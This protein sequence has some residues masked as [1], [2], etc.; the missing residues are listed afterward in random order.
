[1]LM[2]RGSK[3]LGCREINFSHECSIPLNLYDID[4]GISLYH[5][6]LRIILHAMSSLPSWLACNCW[7]L[8]D[9]VSLSI[10]LL[11]RRREQSGLFIIRKHCQGYASGWLKYIVAHGFCIDLSWMCCRRVCLHSISSIM[12]SVEIPATHKI[13][14]RIELD[15]WN[16]RAF[17]EVA[18]IEIY[19]MRMW[20]KCLLPGS[21]SSASALCW[22]RA[23]ATWYG[24]CINFC[25]NSVWM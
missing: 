23:W 13:N 22:W 15:V 12:S 17:L 6:G 24:F 21:C 20:F 19:N 1:M 9:V 4:S 11:R 2:I 10:L 3:R 25:E 7:V 8:Q 18:V 14:W 5:L 16:L